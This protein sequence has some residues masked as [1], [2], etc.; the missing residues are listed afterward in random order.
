MGPHK[1]HKAAMWM[2]SAPT[3]KDTLS[4]GPLITLSHL[5]PE[6]VSRAIALCS[7]GPSVDTRS[8]SQLCLLSAG[9][10]QWLTQPLWSPVL[11][12]RWESS[13]SYSSGSLE[14]QMS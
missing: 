10:P 13:H 6:K 1:A 5:H 9:Q 4:Q 11:I 7:Q 8:K 12:C 3:C 2:P 14:R